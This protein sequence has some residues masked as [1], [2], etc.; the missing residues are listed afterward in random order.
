[1]AEGAFDSWVAKARLVRIEDEIGRRN[2]KLRRQGVEL[3]GPCPKCGGDDRFAIN[4]RSKS[5]IVA[6][7]TK[8]V[9]TLHSYSTSMVWISIA[10]SPR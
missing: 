5:G 2:I 3:V 8:A 7:A 4:E 10:P 9:T 1:V 6:V